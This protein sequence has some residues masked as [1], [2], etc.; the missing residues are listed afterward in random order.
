MSF[1]RNVLI[2]NGFLFV[3]LTP[4]NLVGVNMCEVEYS[5]IPLIL[6]V[7][8]LLNFLYIFFV[9]IFMLKVDVQM[10]CENKI[11]FYIESLAASY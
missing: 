10:F 8:K 7:G 1:D 11:I 2:W 6:S 3:S 4:V 5:Y 9:S